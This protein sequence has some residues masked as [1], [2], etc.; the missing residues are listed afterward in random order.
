M[1]S[2]RA[3]ARPT[4]LPS[5][6]PAAAPRRCLP[7]ADAVACSLPIVEQPAVTIPRPARTG[8]TPKDAPNEVGAAAGGQARACSRR[9]R[10]D[11]PPP[12]LALTLLPAL[13]G[14]VLPCP[15]CTGH[16]PHQG[17]GVPGV[18]HADRHAGAVPV[19]ARR[20]PATGRRRP[21]VAHVCAHAGLPRGGQ[22]GQACCMPRLPTQS[23][24]R[25]LSLAPF[26]SLHPSSCQHPRGLPGG[27][28]A[29]RG[30]RG[31]W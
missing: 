2:L 3:I 19:R 13:R 28:E 5:P 26:L 1:H 22:P 10:P 20:P 17:R 16:V 15:A 18:P 7:P 25:R 4:L 14:P 9:R 6:P 21:V 12:E 29:L 24:C 30:P 8:S 11:A 27:N 31:G 23:P